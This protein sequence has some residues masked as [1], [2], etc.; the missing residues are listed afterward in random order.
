MIGDGINV[1]IQYAVAYA[2]VPDPDCIHGWVTHVLQEQAAPVE[3]VVRVV[4][5]AEITA[6]NARYRGKQGP[7][8]V[9][10]FSADAPAEIDSPLI[11]DIVICAPVVAAE[12]TAQDKS[13]E[14]HWSHL[15]IHGLL[16]LLGYDH[17]HDEEAHRMEQY[18]TRLLGELGYA[19]PYAPPPG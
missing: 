16:H 14:A 6:L 2:G 10:S 7:T 12:A 1:D 4:D 9:L 15:V 19:D 3:V 18:E 13:L 11:G 17:H 5:E 8:N